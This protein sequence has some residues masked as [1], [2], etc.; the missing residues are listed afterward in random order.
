MSCQ[1]LTKQGMPCRCPVKFVVTEIRLC[2]RHYD[3]IN[4]GQVLTYLDA[5]KH[6]KTIDVGK[7]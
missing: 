4:V 2:G 5:N 7:K 1:A 6:V 3:M